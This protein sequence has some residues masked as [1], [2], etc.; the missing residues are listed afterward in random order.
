MTQITEQSV[1]PVPGTSAQTPTA[2][3]T[4]APGGRS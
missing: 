3:A 4:A 1:R 2:A